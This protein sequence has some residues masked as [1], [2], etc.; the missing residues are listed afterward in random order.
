MEI[1]IYNT[2]YVYIPVLYDLHDWWVWFTENIGFPTR[3][4]AD[5]SHEAASS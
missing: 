3:P 2:P 1:Y 4:P 5:S